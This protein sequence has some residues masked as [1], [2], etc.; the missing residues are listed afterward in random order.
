MYWNSENKRR[1]S[2]ILANE[3]RETFNFPWS[4]K[5]FSEIGDK[6][7]TGGN[8][9]LPRVWR[10]C[11]IASEG[12]TPLINAVKNLPAL[13]CWLVFCS[14]LQSKQQKSTATVAIIHVLLR[15]VMALWWPVCLSWRV[16]VHR[17]T[18]YVFMLWTNCLQ[19][20]CSLPVYQEAL[21]P[22]FIPYVTAWSFLIISRP[23]CRGL[24]IF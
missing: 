1:S 2:E 16:I 17:N 24:R 19:L 22:T 14:A 6:S 9:S 4:L 11:I 15:F 8:A 12:W 3:H 13:W 10:P 5:F 7:E 23:L 20:N 18:R 21:M